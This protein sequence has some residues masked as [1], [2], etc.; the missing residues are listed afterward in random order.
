MSF[1][2][3]ANV[4]IAAPAEL[5]WE[6]ITDFARYGE[7]NSFVPEC[8]SSLRPG[9]PIDMRVRL[10]GGVRRQRE[11]VRAH[12]PGTRF[13]YSM[14]PV[15]LG[16]LHSLREHTVTSIDAGHARYTSHFEIA[17]WLNPVVSALLGSSLR[18]GFGAMT[19][20][21]KRR[22]ETLHAS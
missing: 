20:D 5:V 13:S 4:E 9:D 12:E 6:V 18:R 2:I 21:I 10:A 8:S 19:E 15:P 7:W 22:A 16:T 14:K 11:F 1:V 3:D 17:G